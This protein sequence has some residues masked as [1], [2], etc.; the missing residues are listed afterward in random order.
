[1]NY[2]SKILF[3][4]NNRLPMP[5]VRHNESAL[6]H[7]SR[8]S[9]EKRRPQPKR[10]PDYDYDVKDDE[11]ED[12]DDEYVDVETLPSIAQTKS[13]SS[14]EPKVKVPR[15]SEPRPERQLTGR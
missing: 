7:P 15:L 10:M 4:V 2:A 9:A 3:P 5:I 12:E 13:V 14:L 8:I 6:V 1:M 11:E